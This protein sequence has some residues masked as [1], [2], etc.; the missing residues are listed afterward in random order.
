METE[1][2]ESRDRK[3]RGTWDSRHV[4]QEVHGVTDMRS[5]G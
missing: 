4:A 1:I 3:Q 5:D 2:H